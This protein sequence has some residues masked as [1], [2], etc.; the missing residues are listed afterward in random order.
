MK[1]KFE[2]WRAREDSLFKIEHAQALLDEYAKQGYVLSLRQLYYQFVAR[3]IIPNTEREYEKLGHMVNRARLAGLLDWGHIEDRGRERRANAHWST[4]RESIESLLSLY[5]IDK[6][7]NQEYYLEVWVEKDALVEVVAQA[8]RPLD[9]SYFAC[10]GYNS[11]S[12]MYQAGKRLQYQSSQG[13]KPIVLHLGDHDPSGIDMT[14]DNE[15]RL[16]L[17]AR[18]PIQV[19]RLAL[20]MDQV[21]FYNPPPNPTKLTDSRA[22]YY[23]SQFGASSWEL[24]ALEPL[25]LTE[26]IKA[27]VNKYRD[28]DAWSEALKRESEHKQELG[29]A[30]KSMSL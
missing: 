3:D 2:N 14:F 17:F 5:Q 8:C 18:E 24:D 22:K 26:I 19:E 28:G 27:N 6:W 30:L 12:E 7:E 9:V 29:R 23:V 16:S 1:E 15:R 20:N 4:P 21:D 11:Q 25:A 10:R 13:K